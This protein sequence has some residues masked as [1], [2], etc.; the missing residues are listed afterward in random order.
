VRR[1]RSDLTRS[2]AQQWITPALCRTA[3]GPAT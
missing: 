2:A 3:R 1:N